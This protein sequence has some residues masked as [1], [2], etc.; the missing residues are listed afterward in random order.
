MLK[1]TYQFYGRRPIYILSLAI[2]TIWIVP[3]AVAKNI[4]TML[5]SRFFNGVAGAAFLSVAGGKPFS[6]KLR[7][8]NQNTPVPQILRLLETFY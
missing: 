5:V 8:W 3:C 1:V 2:F 6:L 4:E 7:L